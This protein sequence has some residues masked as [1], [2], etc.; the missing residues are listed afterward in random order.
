MGAGWRESHVRFCERLAARLRRP[1]HRNLY[2][3]SEQAELRVMASLARFI[4]RR[5][6]LQVNAQKSAVARPWQR[7]FPGFTLADEAESRR[8]IADKA[9]AGFKDRVR[10]LTRRHSRTHRAADR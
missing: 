6:K 7:S 2:D 1:T 10:D 9:L 8:R 3:H 5:L 4:E